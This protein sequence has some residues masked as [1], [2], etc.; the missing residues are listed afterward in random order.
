MK[1][2]RT[3]TLMVA[4]CGT[5]ALG[6]VTTASAEDEQPSEWK[7][8]DKNDDCKG[9]CPIDQGWICPCVIF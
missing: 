9:T 1:L 7:W 5:A 3:L 6:V 2:T 4:L 8:V